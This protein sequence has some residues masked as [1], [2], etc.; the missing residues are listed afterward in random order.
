MD[1]IPTKSSHDIFGATDNKSALPPF[2]PF[3]RFY[4]RDKIFVIH[5]A[6]RL[7]ERL[8]VLNLA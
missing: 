5:T 7:K 3:C 1:A 4:G 2:E 8:D 6:G